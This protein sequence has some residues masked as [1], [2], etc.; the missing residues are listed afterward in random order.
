MPYALTYSHD[1]K[2]WLVSRSNKS[3]DLVQRVF[4][5][6]TEGIFTVRLHNCHGEIEIIWTSEEGW[7]DAEF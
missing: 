5:L 7:L 1:D 3:G 4:G 2:E 6:V